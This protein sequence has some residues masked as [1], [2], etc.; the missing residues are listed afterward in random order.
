MTNLIREIIKDAQ[1]IEGDRDIN[2][3]TL[4]IS[5]GIRKTKGVIIVLILFTVLF[6]GFF[7]HFY[8]TDWISQAYY[9]LFLLLPFGY[10]AIRTISSA[11]NRD[12]GSLSNWTKAIM[13]MGLLYAPIAHWLIRNFVTR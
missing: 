3:H 12:F 7:F 6:L 13:L 11:G 1:D 2:S 5:V 9:I 10:V 8:L 4:P